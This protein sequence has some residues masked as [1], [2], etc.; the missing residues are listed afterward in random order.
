MMAKRKRT[1]SAESAQ[2]AASEALAMAVQTL[3]QRGT[4]LDDAMRQVAV[5]AGAPLAAAMAA[6]AAELRALAEQPA[7]YALILPSADPAAVVG[8]TPAYALLARNTGQLQVAKMQNF[9]H[10]P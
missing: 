9:Y 2:Q 3:M 4:P 5:V 10:R 8:G 6:A 7:E 1:A